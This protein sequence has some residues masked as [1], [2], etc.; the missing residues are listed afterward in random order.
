[1]VCDMKGWEFAKEKCPKLCGV[2]KPGDGKPCR[3]RSK[4]SALKRIMLGYLDNELD[5]MVDE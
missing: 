4:I 2:C 3:Q 5:D 1:M